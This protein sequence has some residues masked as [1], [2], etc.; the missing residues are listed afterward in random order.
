MVLRIVLS[1][2]LV[3]VGI[4]CGDAPE[5]RR[6][7]PGDILKNE[8]KLYS[9]FDEELIIRDFFNDRRDGFFIDVGCAFAMKDSTTYY[10]E[11]HLGWTGIGIDALP[12]YAEGWAASRPNS[13]FVDYAVTDHSGDTLTFYR[14]SVPTVSSLQSELVERWQGPAPTEIKVTTITLDKLLVV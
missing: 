12:E 8:V 4:S 6:A 14:A 11:Q 3:V 1:A 2:A 10:L 7:L 9:Q 13:L 5:P